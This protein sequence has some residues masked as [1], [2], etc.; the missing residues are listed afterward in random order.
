MATF[1]E[2]IFRGLIMKDHS[3]D[4]VENCTAF[5]GFGLNRETDEDTVQYY[6]QKFSD[7]TLMAT[8]K[9]RMTDDELETIFNLLSSI[10]KKHLSEPEY[11][12]LFLKDNHE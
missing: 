7:D 8:L 11:H 6:L 1:P 10:L 9:K 3:H 5:I 2:H 4:F 12:E